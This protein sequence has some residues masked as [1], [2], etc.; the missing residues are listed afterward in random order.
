MLNNSERLKKI[1][2]K[3]KFTIRAVSDGA[4]IPIRTYQNYEY[5][6]REI[7]TEALFKL[8]DFYGVTTDYLLGRESAEYEERMN[9]KYQTLSPKG[10]EAVAKI[11]TALA[12]AHNP[13]HTTEDKYV[14]LTTIG[15][16]L[17]A[18]GADFTKQ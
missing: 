2:K 3:R 10:K 8:A 15:E 11:I 7:S 1:R 12:E 13:E 5:G 16:V 9:A 14:A 17:T 4:E 6:E 18:I